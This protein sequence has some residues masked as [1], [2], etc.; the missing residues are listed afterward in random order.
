MQVIQGVERGLV[1]VEIE[2]D[3]GFHNPWCAAVM[4]LVQPPPVLPEA[5]SI[6]CECSPLCRS[7]PLQTRCSE[8]IYIHSVHAYYMCVCTYHYGNDHEQ[9][10]REYKKQRLENSV[11]WALSKIKFQL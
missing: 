5:C 7:T 10:D 9:N 8:S 1:E 2:A 6:H 11:F 4:T 3:T